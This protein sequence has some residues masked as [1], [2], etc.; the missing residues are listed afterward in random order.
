MLISPIPFRLIHQWPLVLA[1]SSFFIITNK[2]IPL[3]LHPK[4]VPT[5]TRQNLMLQCFHDLLTNVKEVTCK[6]ENI[7][8]VILKFFK[9]N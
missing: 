1:L 6:V 4:I 3:G 2:S 9:I 8:M 5:H 7:I